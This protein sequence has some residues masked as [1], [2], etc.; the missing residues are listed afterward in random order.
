VAFLVGSYDGSGNYGDIA[1][2]DGALGMLGKL[3]GGLPVLPVLERQY[4][5]THETLRSDFL[6][7]PEHALYFDDGGS[8]DDDLVPLPPAQHGFA[9]SYLYGGGFLNPSWG[10]RKLAMLRTVEEVAQGAGAVTRIAS[11]QQ[12]DAGW[13]SQLD[14]ADARLLAS[15]EIL[16]ARDAASAEVL[17]QLAGPG[18]AINSGDDAVG[19]LGEVATRRSGRPSGEALEINV[20]IADHPW[21]TDRPDSVRD[22]VVGLLAALSRLAG[23]PLRVRPLLAYLDPRVDERPGLER[24]AAACA[25]RGIEVGEPLVAR[26]A[27]APEAA[28]ELGGAALTISCSYHVAL[29]SLLLAVPT[30]ILRDNP[31]Y[32]QKAKGLLS[33]FALPEPFSPSSGDDPERCA[34]A[35]AGVLPERGAEAERER[36]RD[37]ASE[38]R[39]RRADAEAAL[40]ARVARGSIAAAAADPP[41]PPPAAAQPDPAEQ[42][43][44]EAERREAEARA[45]LDALLTSR[46]WKITAPLRR[47]AA[48]RRSR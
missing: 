18:V 17:E 44:E 2:L 30:V 10:E 22:F 19:I 29:T 21:V 25:E 1:Q 43:A 38:V 37:A 4:A 8:F 39:Q 5:A 46:S 13:I 15:F 41:S 34:A 33:D 16:G 35:I 24:F 9:L 47:L 45:E 27:T 28:A 31:Y 40:L 3:E 14:R 32:D 36:L 6:H 12:V 11:G 23:R 20:H 26:P 7:E 48:A 42:R